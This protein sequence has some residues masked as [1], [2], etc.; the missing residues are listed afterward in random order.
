MDD[1]TCKC[2]HDAKLHTAAGCLIIGGC[3]CELSSEKVLRVHITEQQARLDTNRAQVT[4]LIAE[5][6]ALKNQLRGW[7][8]GLDCWADEKGISDLDDMMEEMQE[9][10]S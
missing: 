8:S 4:A 10:L 1:I 6:D 3:W 7:L 5:R 2:G 9:A